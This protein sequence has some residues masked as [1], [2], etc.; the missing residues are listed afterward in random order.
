M[1]VF[2][3]LGNFAKNALNILIFGRPLQKAP[4]T[5]ELLTEIQRTKARD[6]NQRMLRPSLV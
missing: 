4:E 3:V 5:T 1:G 2:G 6:L